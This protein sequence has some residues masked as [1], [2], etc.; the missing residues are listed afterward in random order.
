MDRASQIRRAS[1]RSEALTPLG[2]AGRF[3]PLLIALLLVA[4]L[5]LLAGGLVFSYRLAYTD[6]LFRGVQVG[7]VPV[8]GM[9]KEETIAVL[10]P[11]YYEKANRT[12]VLRAAGMEWISSMAGLGASFDV[13]AATEAA[14]G[15]GRTGRWWRGCSPRL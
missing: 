13:A 11:L 15:V 3:R 10:Q 1:G 9:S 8:G 2:W 4:G 12:L 5:A 7:G 6:T 14:Y